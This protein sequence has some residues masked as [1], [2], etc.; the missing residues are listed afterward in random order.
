M[1]LDPPSEHGN[2]LVLR[3]LSCNDQVIKH[4]VC[5]YTTR[6]TEKLQNSR[7]S[8]YFRNGAIQVPS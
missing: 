4:E 2:V 1:D 7:D 6:S 8:K 5:F 3:L